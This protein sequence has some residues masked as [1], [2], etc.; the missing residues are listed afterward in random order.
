MALV[1]KFQPYKSTSSNLIDTIMLF[2][3]VSISQLSVMNLIYDN[4]KRGILVLKFL[5]KLPSSILI[6]IP[7]S[8]AVLLV[9]AKLIP[10]KYYRKV[11][12][13]IRSR[14]REELLETTNG[15]P[16]YQTF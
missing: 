10:V 3:A 2:V 8:Y 9:V 16:N 15:V 4:L 7:L 5:V 6:L 13:K 12:S 14:A 11:L 1:I